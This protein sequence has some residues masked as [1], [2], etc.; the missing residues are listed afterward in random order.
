MKWKR[1]LCVLFFCLI[2]P[3]VG[4]THART[5]HD[6]EKEIADYYVHKLHGTEKLLCIGCRDGYL[7]EYFAEQLPS[8][9][10]VGIDTEDNPYLPAS[11][12]KVT[13][14][15]GQMADMQWENHFDVVVSVHSFEW[16]KD[17]LQAFRAIYRA[18]KPGALLYWVVCAEGGLSIFEMYKQ[19]GKKG[20]L[21]PWKISTFG[22]DIEACRQAV[23]EVGFLRIGGDHHRYELNYPP[24]HLDQAKNDMR[25][26][27]REFWGRTDEEI[28]LFLQVAGTW[29][30]KPAVLRTPFHGGIWFMKK[31]ESG[32]PQSYGFDTE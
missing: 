17:P 32:D 4:M 6:Y 10:V 25:I 16:E 19:A 31:P 26:W 15:K 9:E 30:G 14:V 1:S 27:F 2:S 13:Y 18:M 7:T 12:E 23:Q 20:F 21:L 24:E 11:H 5:F 28:D 8:G 29:L 3:V 22:A